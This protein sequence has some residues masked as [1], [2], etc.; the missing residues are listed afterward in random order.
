MRVS[1]AGLRAGRACQDWK[2]FPSGIFVACLAQMRVTFQ[3]RLGAMTRDC[4]DLWDV[5]TDF[6]QPG[7]TIVTKIIRCKS[8][9]S[10]NWHARVK[11]VPMV[12]PQ[13]GKISSHLF[14]IERTIWSASRGRSHHTSFPIFSPGFFISRI[15]TRLPSSRSF[16]EIRVNLFQPTRRKYR[17]AD[18]LLH[19]NG[20]GAALQ[21]FVKIFR[22]F[23]SSSMLGW[24]SRSGLLLAIPRRFATT[25]ASF[26]AVWSSGYAHARLATAKT[27]PQCDG[28]DQD[29]SKRE[30]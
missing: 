2:P 19:R 3:A 13:N 10:R 15:K 21:P 18:D 1:V 6:E 9:I 7:N 24:R 16:H 27:A 22:I 8:M 17:K 5:S 12:S 14:G 30:A 11:L 4:C 25:K 26:M 20:G 29:F 28:L 23:S